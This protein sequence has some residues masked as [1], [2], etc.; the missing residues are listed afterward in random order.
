M[1]KIKIILIG[2]SEVG[3]TCLMTQFIKSKFENELIPTIASDKVIKQ[4]EKKILN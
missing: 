4:Y 2:E 3:K 1:D